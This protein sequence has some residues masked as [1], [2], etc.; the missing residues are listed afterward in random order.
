MCCVTAIHTNTSLHSLCLACVTL[1]AVQIPL[2]LALGKKGSQLTNC[3]L[4][5]VHPCTQTKH[6]HSWTAFAANCSP[7]ARP[8]HSHLFQVP[9]LWE[10][11]HVS[12]WMSWGRKMVPPMTR[13][14]FKHKSARHPQ[15]LCFPMALSQLVLSSPTLV[16]RSPV[17]KGMS[18][19]GTLDMTWRRCSYHSSFISSLASFVG[20]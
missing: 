9:R 18:W 20:A 19:W 5:S 3:V 8:Q 11:L 17:I 7:V 13:L 1:A 14:L 10:C 6:M 12:L 16:F 15:H 2:G 4:F